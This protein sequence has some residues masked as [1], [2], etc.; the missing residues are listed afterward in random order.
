MG[1]DG[2]PERDVAEVHFC[3][4]VCPLTSFSKHVLLFQRTNAQV[5]MLQCP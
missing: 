5:S 4:P 1:E 3:C 2:Q